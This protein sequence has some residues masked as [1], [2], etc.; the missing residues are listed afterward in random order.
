MYRG[1][2]DAFRHIVRTEGF[3]ALYKGFWVNT[4]QVVSG[5]E[6]FRIIHIE[7]ELT[8]PFLYRFR[9]YIDL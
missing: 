7:I 3:S 5:N 9:L 2:A 4:M 1:T 6:C 8:L